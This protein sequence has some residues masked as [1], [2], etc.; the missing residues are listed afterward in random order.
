MS[1][2]LLLLEVRTLTGSMM[3]LDAVE[4]Q[5]GVEVAQ[6]E[7]ND[8]YGILLKLRGEVAA[9][10]S[11]AGAARDLA[12]RFQLTLTE[13]NLL[14]PTPEALAGILPADEFQPLLGQKVV[15]G[16]R[17]PRDNKDHESMKNNAEYTALGFIETQGFT[18]SMAA[19]DAATKAA[20]VEL[21]GR[22]K[23]GGGYITVVL[24]GDIAAVSA[25]VEAG[26]QAV[27]SL[28]TLIAGN[29]I[30]RPSQGVNAL[31]ETVRIAAK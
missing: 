24:A 3:V 9:V 6:A 5:A 23:L 7:L 11:A 22:E 2:A 18:A 20:E 1:P 17:N 12:E 25:A 30:S 31:L 15:Y 27:E 26:V 14:N 13:T 10:E 19:L 21:V 16:P 29:V 8:Y 28:G 4:K